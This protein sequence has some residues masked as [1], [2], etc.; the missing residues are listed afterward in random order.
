MKIIKFVALIFI[1]GLY[2]CTQEEIINE[3][4]EIS[5][6]P[7][8]TATFEQA[9]SRTF[10]EKGKYL[11][12]TAEDCISF[13]YKTTYNYQYQFDGE[14]G[15]NYGGFI[16]MTPSG[17]VITG[18]N[19]DFNC[20]VYPY[21][22]DNKV[23]ENGIFTLNMPAEQ[24]YAPNSFGLG[25][26]I[27]VAKTKNIEDTFLSFKNVGG[28]LKLLLYGKDITVKSITLQ[29]KNGE[30]LAGKATVTPIYGGVPT[31]EM[32]SEATETVT[33]DCGEGVTLST[34]ADNATPFFLVVPPT[35]FTK[36]FTVTVT[37]TKGRTFKKSTNNSI[38]IKRNVIKP[39]NEIEVVTEK[40]I[41]Y[42]TFTTEATQTFTMSESVEKLEYSVGDGE[43][44]TLG[45]TTVTF[46]GNNGDL[47]LRG[48]N[49]Y[50]TTSPY[51]INN[52]YSQISFGKSDVL[53]A[54]NGDIR[55]LVD[56]ENYATVNT[57]YARFYAL[58]NEC[59]NLTKAPDL[60]ATVLADHCYS[61]MFWGCKNLTKAPMLPAT[62]LAESCYE[63]MFRDCE[64]LTE[65]PVLSA[66]NLTKH[67]YAGMFD[68][69]KNLTEAPNLPASI[70]AEYCY[71]CMFYGCSKL[72]SISMLATDISAH[73]CLSEWVKNVSSIGTF[74]K[75]KEMV[76]LPEGASG[77][78]SGWFVKDYEE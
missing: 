33:L 69:C 2:S 61:Y 10:L 56:Y 28:Y 78:P 1:L 52:N 58:F 31:L 27:M 20:A 55:T 49:K 46:G 53:V 43:W 74:I 38:S 34:S 54:C 40:E 30:K 73:S 13:Y 19:L 57:E 42:V 36:G 76:S 29:G 15:N 5:K 35:E 77:I 41:P 4:Q 25:A 3:S 17:S 72:S 8:V 48:K 65:P 51:S 16:N 44:K 39:M 50:G 62:T 47:R 75:A 32:S 45:T 7:E 66:T 24:K 67:C 18:I 70:L 60:P 21:S 71:D 64:S 63:R 26:N 23:N 9:S 11:C 22:K 59:A 14:T 68:G 12:W 6:G 37:D